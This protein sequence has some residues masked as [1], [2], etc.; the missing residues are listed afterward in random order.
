MP[1][2]A[3]LSLLSF[4]YASYTSPEKWREYAAAGVLTMGIAPYTFGI[5]AGTNGKLATVA[6]GKGKGTGR[7]EEDVLVL[8]RRW[9]GLNLGRSVFPLIGAG[10]GLWALG[11]W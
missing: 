4:T 7:E 8:L 3:F 10:V 9:S 11:G 6:A 5:M 1:S 2:I